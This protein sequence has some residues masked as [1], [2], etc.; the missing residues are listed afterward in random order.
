MHVNLI[1]DTWFPLKC[2][3]SKFKI[4]DSKHVFAVHLIQ[5]KE[6]Y[7]YYTYTLYKAWYIMSYIMT[8][9]EKIWSSANQIIFHAQYSN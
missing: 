8:S 4:Q 1:R 5:E 2:F 7:I 9:Y 6:N 3:L